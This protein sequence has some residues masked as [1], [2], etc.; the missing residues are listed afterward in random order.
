MQPVNNNK[1]GLIFFSSDSKTDKKAISKLT[2]RSF[3]GLSCKSEDT[4]ES[5]ICL[6][7]SRCNIRRL[8]AAL[9][10]VRYIFQIL[11]KSRCNILDSFPSHLKKLRSIL[12]F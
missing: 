7:D 1:N 6:D 10:E 9:K 4:A 8:L 5:V 3:K 11:W 12:R 2:S